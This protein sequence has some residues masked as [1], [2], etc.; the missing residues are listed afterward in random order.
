MPKKYKYAPSVGFQ[1]IKD[2]SMVH[3][4]VPGMRWGS[5]KDGSSGSSRRKS[6]PKASSM[7]DGDLQK[8]VNRLNLEKQYKSLTATSSQRA[9][10][11]VAKVTGE[12]V[13]TVGKKLAVKAIQ[14]G[15]DAVIAKSAPGG[16]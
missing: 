8:A 7:S 3:Y 9:A 14:A 10:S 13:K 6:T 15:V 2:N 16:A 11:A 1:M 4:G 5:R 12:A